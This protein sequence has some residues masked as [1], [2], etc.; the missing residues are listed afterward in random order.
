MD[1]L[2]IW[3]VQWMSSQIV[4]VC[5]HGIKVAKATSFSI[6]NSTFSEW[7]IRD[8]LCSAVLIHPDPR[9][10]FTIIGNQFIRDIDFGE[11]HNNATIT[12]NPGQYNRYIISNNLSYSG[13]R[14]TNL[15]IGCLEPVVDNGT[16]APSKVVT[17]RDNL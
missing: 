12:V 5:G 13:T 8:E 7:N 3:G 4:N 9:T 10:N 11:H 15:G 2:D 14:R 1:N 17:D 6:M 16:T